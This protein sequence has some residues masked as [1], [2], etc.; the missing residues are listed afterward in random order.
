MAKA[1]LPGTPA[2]GAAAPATAAK[3]ALEG[4]GLLET[5]GIAGIGVLARMGDALKLVELAVHE[6][7]RRHCLAAVRRGDA[8][9]AA[10]IAVDPRLEIDCHLAGGG[11]CFLRLGDGGVIQKGD[12]C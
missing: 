9:L 6:E 4:Q 8:K 2:S 12:I 11:H 10:I 5:G 7:N 3:S 1:I